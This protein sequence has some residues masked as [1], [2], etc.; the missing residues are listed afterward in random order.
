MH[1]HSHTQT[2]TVKID[3][4]I[5]SS[6]S[7]FLDWNLGFCRSPNQNWDAAAFFVLLL[8]LIPNPLA[9]WQVLWACNGS[10]IHIYL[11][12]CLGLVHCNLLELDMFCVCAWCR[13]REREHIIKTFHVYNLFYDARLWPTFYCFR[14]VFYHCACSVKLF[15]C[16]TTFHDGLY[17]YFYCTAYMYYV[18]LD[19]K[20]KPWC[21]SSNHPKC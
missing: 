15:I 16:V 14:R 11:L 9:D 7:V 4:C 6:S 21:W 8:L 17:Y 20:W 12:T 10:V 1:T 19:T 18:W 3:S 13:E 5:H 2:H